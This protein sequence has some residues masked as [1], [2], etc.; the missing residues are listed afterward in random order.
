MAIQRSGT[1]DDEN[2]AAAAVDR[3]SAVVPLRPPEYVVPQ[4]VSL[5]LC[6]SVIIS[7]F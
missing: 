2:A 7:H 1:A 3:S 5:I 6:Y 4:G